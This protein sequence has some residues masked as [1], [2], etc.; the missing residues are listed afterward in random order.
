M[1][2]KVGVNLERRHLWSKT[3]KKW[4][5]MD[6]SELHARRLNAREVLTP[7][8][9]DYF[10]FPVADG[11]VKTMKEMTSETIHFNPGSS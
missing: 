9:A 8:K 7:M 11:T 1:L 4:E 10:I 3:L 5:E 6:A 2:K